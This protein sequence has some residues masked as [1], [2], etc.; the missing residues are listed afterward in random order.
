MERTKRDVSVSSS[1][2]KDF[3]TCLKASVAN[4]AL[5]PSFLCKSMMHLVFPA[6]LLRP[7][8]SPIVLENDPTAS[9]LMSK[10]GILKIA[11]TPS[12]RKYPV[13]TPPSKFPRFGCATIGS[14]G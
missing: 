13:I 5:P 12:L 3:P 7:M 11:V 8:N 4:R 6:A 2:G 1:E 14:S 9:A 10:L